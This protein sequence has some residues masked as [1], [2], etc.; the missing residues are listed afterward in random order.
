MMTWCAA[1]AA[2]MSSRLPETGSESGNVIASV[3]KGAEEEGRRKDKDESPV[4]AGNY[5]PS[6]FS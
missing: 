1:S 4:K 6:C 2:A 5:Q 3:D